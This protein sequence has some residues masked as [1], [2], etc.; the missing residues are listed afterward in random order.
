MKLMWLYAMMSA[1]T[2]AAASTVGSIGG[3]VTLLAGN[4]ATVQGSSI[5]TPAGDITVPPI[6]LAEIACGTP[7]APRGKTLGDL[8][9]RL[10]VQ[11]VPYAHR[12]ACAFHAS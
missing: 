3:N 4:N 10:K 2:T 7:P 11:F 5:L 8:A 12:S 1:S 6:V 9:R